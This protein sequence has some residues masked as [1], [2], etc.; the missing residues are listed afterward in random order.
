M[1]QELLRVANAH[2]PGKLAAD[3]REE[4]LLELVSLEVLLLEV[5]HY[6]LDHVL[7]VDLGGRR[8]LRLRDDSSRRRLAVVTRARLVL[9]LAPKRLLPWAWHSA[10]LPP[11]TCGSR[12]R[13]GSHCPYTQHSAQWAQCIGY[14]AGSLA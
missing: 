14:S 9:A 10:R 6:L 2:A 1:P 8:H 5:P 12:V 7:G 13:A 4:A 3:W 11:V